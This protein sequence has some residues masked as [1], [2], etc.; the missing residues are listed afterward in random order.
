[1]KINFNL[2]DQAAWTSGK[3]GEK[4]IWRKKIRALQM[5]LQLKIASITYIGPLSTAYLK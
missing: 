3:C 5:P 4:E 1:L 2:S